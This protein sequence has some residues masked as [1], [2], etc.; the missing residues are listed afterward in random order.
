MILA[1]YDLGRSPLTYDFTHWLAAVE[2]QRRES[3]EKE[4]RVRFVMGERLVTERDQHFTPERKA[5]RLHNLLVPLCRLL[6]CVSSYE[7]G[8][9]GEQNFSYHPPRPVKPETFLKASGAAESL[10]A[11][12]LRTDKRVVTITIRQSDLQ[13]ARNSNLEEWRRVAAWLRERN[14][15]AVFVP[16]TE[17]LMMGEPMDY[18][19]FRVCQPAAMNPDI[20]LALYERATLNCFTSG[21]PFGLPL[22][23]G[24][25]FLLCKTVFPEYRSC[26]K[27]TQDKLGYTPE[28]FPGPL[29]RISWCD[30]AA[31]DLTAI[32]AAMLP[33]CD[34]RER[35]LPRMHAFAVQRPHRIENIKAVG[36]ANPRMLIQVPAHDRTA[37]LVCY[38]PS[39]ADTWHA[40]A[41]GGTDIFTVSGAHDFL[42]ER[43]IVPAGHI[44]ADPRPHKAMFTANADRRVHY[45]LASCCDPLVYANVKDCQVTVWHSW[46]GDEVEREVLKLWPNAFLLLGGSNVGLRGIAVLSA[47]GYRNIQI[48]GMDCSLTDGQRHAGVHNGKLQKIR[49]VRAESSDIEFQTTPQMVSGAQEFIGLVSKLAPL[50]FRFDVYGHGLMQEMLRVA[51]RPKS[52]EFSSLPT[53]EQHGTERRTAGMGAV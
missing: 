11:S 7:I 25:P 32:L 21:G 48:H 33:A 46:D 5:W 52:E 22:Y 23:S 17:A 37:S 50:G 28:Q 35:P 14:Y 1:V 16:D 34:A 9:E 2:R 42:L 6:P 3:G 27:E 10:I 45:Y 19:D 31:D 39:I 12:W 20:R 24:L 4:V 43:G 29:Q 15:L 51:M 41:A 26:L 40:L 38:G 30:D 13:T 18:G 36:A 8:R 53:G 47:L 44:E 49:T